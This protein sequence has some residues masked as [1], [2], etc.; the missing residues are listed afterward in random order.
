MTIPAT[1]V[2]VSGL[3]FSA[4]YAL[5]GPVSEARERAAAISVEQTIEFPPDLIAND[6]IRGHVIGRVETVDETGPERVL[7]RISYAIETSGSE[8]PQLLNVL[9][10]NASLLPGVRLMDLE[11]PPELLARFRGPRFGIAGLR[12]LLEAPDRPLVATALK[13]MGLNSASLA[14]MARTL[15]LAGLDIIKDDHGLANQPFA[16]Y[17]ERVRACAEAVRRANRETGGRSIYL[18]SINAPAEQIVSRARAAKEAGA[19]GLLV[20]PGFAGLDTMRALADDDDLDLP[21]M[22][23]PA[24][25]GS[26]VV[27]E[28]LGIEHGTLFGTIMRLAGADISI[29]PG[30]GGR[31]SFNRPACRSIL[32]ACRAPLGTVAPTMPAP[33]GGVTLDRIDEVVGFYGSDSVLLI[34]GDL[35]RGDLIDNARRM[36]A[37]VEVAA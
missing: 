27:D 4:T 37:A 23:H 12:R 8:L 3:R 24:F 9:F 32:E 2:A 33:G 34:G 5:S 25:L 14:E 7:V 26:Y 22:A 21:I 1:T 20:L 35:H 31:F 36:R 30:Y 19:G 6:D 18:P 15:A 13:P 10:G 29:F 17:L 28:K 11:V 16:P